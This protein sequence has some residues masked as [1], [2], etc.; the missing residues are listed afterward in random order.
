MVINGVDIEQEFSVKLIDVE[1]NLLPDFRPETVEI[2]R[3]GIKYVGRNQILSLT[4]TLTFVILGNSK[5]D[6]LERRKA[7]FL[8]LAPFDSEKEIR[9]D[10]ETGVR[11]GVISANS[12]R[13]KKFGGN[14]LY[15]IFSLDFTF[16]D[17][18]Q[19]SPAFEETVI[20]ANVG[21]QYSLMNGGLETPFVVEITTLSYLG[22][23]EAEDIA[24]NVNGDIIKYNGI[25]EDSDVLKIDTINFKIEKNGINV[26]SAMEGEF[27]N[28]KTGE[29]FIS[30]NE[31][32]NNGVTLKFLVRERWF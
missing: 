19:Y 20:D 13:E 8:F 7:F 14:N 23:I 28:L 10:N 24:L 16:F 9:F 22:G 6:L 5:D 3:V 1:G 18:Y 31:D 29:N 2:P 15:N 11:Y 32:F 26:I 12:L 27:M 30:V 21:T 17:P 4:K 25:L